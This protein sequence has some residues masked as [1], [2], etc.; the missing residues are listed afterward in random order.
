MRN[1]GG[2]LNRYKVRHEVAINE[3]YRYGVSK[4]TSLLT[5]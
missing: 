1:D 5:K 2:C 4:G 3:K